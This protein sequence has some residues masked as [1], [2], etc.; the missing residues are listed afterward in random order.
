M[1]MGRTHT[2]KT[3]YINYKTCSNMEPARKEEERKTQSHLEKK[4]RAGDEGTRTVMATAGAEGT[5]PKGMEEPRQW[6]MFLREF[7]GLK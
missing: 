1:D 7:K 3:H 5:R 4:H 2:A 6:P